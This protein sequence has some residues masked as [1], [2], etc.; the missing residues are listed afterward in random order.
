M[1]IVYVAASSEPTQRV[2]AKRLIDLLTKAGVHCTSTWIKNVE[3]VHKGVANPRDDDVARLTAVRMNESAIDEATLLW[4]LV[5]GPCDSDKERVD[6]PARGG[7]YELGYA[8][9]QKKALV[10]SG[11]SKQS[12]CCSRASEFDDDLDAFAFIMKLARS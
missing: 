8:A 7:Y 4:F 9:A 3:D 6:S 10:C 2:R 12:V 11:D 5:P 1:T